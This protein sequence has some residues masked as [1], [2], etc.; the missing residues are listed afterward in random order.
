MPKMDDCAHMHFSFIQCVYEVGYNTMKLK[1][2]H[3]IICM[4]VHVFYIY[5]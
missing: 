5:Y 4:N 1:V 2:T 3:C